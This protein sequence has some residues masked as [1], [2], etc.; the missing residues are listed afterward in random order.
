MQP[1]IVYQM[2]S[3]APQGTFLLFEPVTTLAEWDKYPAMMQSLKNAGGR[4]FEALQKDF[5]EITLFEESR[6]M[7]ISPQMSYVSKE[8]VAGDPNFWTL[9]QAKPASSKAA[10]KRPAAKPT[11]Q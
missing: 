10:K 11:G 4:K 1:V 3:G 9:K 2:I 8:T 5:Q 7:A 6:L